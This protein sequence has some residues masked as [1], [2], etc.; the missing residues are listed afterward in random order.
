MCTVS[1]DVIACFVYV[2]CNVI[3]AELCFDCSLVFLEMYFQGSARLSNVYAPT[4]A[5]YLV[6]CTL[7]PSLLQVCP[8]PCLEWCTLFCVTG[9]QPSI[10]VSTGSLITLAEVTYTW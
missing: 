9:I 3:A 6:Y 7:S 1:L 10:Q 5:A 2:N 4:A 8:P